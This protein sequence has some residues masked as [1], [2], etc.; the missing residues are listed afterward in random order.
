MAREF[1]C[2]ESALS[3]SLGAH[4]EELVLTGDADVRGVGNSLDNRLVGNTGDNVLDGKRGADTMAGGL[5]DDLYVVDDAGDVVTETDDAGSD[6]VRSAVDYGLG[7][8]IEHLKL[9]GKATSGAG[10]ALDNSVIGNARNNTLDGGDG[11]DTI[12]GGNGNDTLSGGAG[13][14]VLDGYKGA[15][16]AS[17]AGA[18]GAVNVDLALSEAQNT[19]AAGT[20]RLI[21]IERLIGGDYADTLAGN[22]KANHLDGGAGADTLSGGTGNDTYIV[23]DADDTVVEANRG[24]YDVVESAVSHTLAANVER[25]ELT[26]AD[27]IDATGNASRNVLKGNDG[28][29][30]L[31]GGAGGDRLVGGLGDDTYVVDSRYDR[32]VEARNGGVDEVKS[33]VHFTLASTLEHLELTGADNI[34]GV[35]NGLDNRLVGNTGD[36]VLDGKRGAD[37]MAGGRG[38]DLYVVDDAGDVVTEND[39]AGSDT[40]RSAVDYGLGDHIEHLKLT[41]K[42]TSGAGNALDNSVIGN[43]RNNTLDGG[44]GDDT[45]KGGNGND[46]L[47][48]GAGNDVLDGYKGADCASYA[49]ATGAVNVDLALSEAQNTGAAGTDR[50]IAIERLIGGDYAD[51]LAGNRKANHLDGGA[52]A[53][54]LSG[55]TGNDTYIVDDAGD[56]VVEANRGGYDVVESAV[57][58]TLAANV[59]RLELTGA[60]DI[61][62]T[63]NAS[64]N[65]LKGNDGANRLDGGAGGDRLVGGLGDDTYVVDSRYDRVVEARNGGVDEVKSAVHFTLA[66]TLEH[67]E[68]TGADNIKGVGNGLDNRLVGNTGDNVLDGKRGADTMA[69]GRGDDLYVVDDAGDVVTEN[70]TAGSDTVRSAVDYG[71]GD[72]IEHLKLTGKATSGAGNALD[73]SVIGNARNNTLDGGDG[74]DTIKGGN[75]NDTLSGGA[76]NDVLDGYKGADCASYAGATGA[77]NVDLALSEAQ[78][79][80]AAGTDRLIAIERLIGGDYAD[81]LAGNRKANHLDGGAGADTLSGGTG[82]DTYIVDDAGDTVVEANRGGYDV[83]ESAVSHTLAANVERLELTGA[84]DIDATGNASRNVLKGNDGANRLDGGAGGDRLVGGLGDD[85]YVVDS[86]YDRVVEARNGGVDEVKSAVH[87]TLSSTLEHLELTGANPVN[88]VGNSL[89]NR[90]VGNAGDNRLVGERRRRYAERRVRRRYPRGRIGR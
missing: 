11:D 59:E 32:V 50:L 52:G 12:K 10:N 47:S 27:D 74:D 57:S 84:D 77:V 28:A 65:V 56:T 71:L 24:G 73:N 39:T 9:T 37:T 22:R 17:Y 41:G 70:D 49:G 87:F 64:R 90:L 8:H 80:G 66:S 21:A 45:I 42:A 61:D 31:D 72:H 76:G 3:L 78:N 48:G 60:D 18:T 6:T 79:T 58:H 54:T 16:C 53:D 62:A 7:D 86:R 2:I 55:G 26:G 67:L 40:V 4:I 82:N 23:D 30:R 15:D 20:D 38:D 68:L 35:G 36:N 13:N 34:K 89:D 81:T 43:A 75:G 5:G 88:G 46:T 83:V 51:T 25:L 69:G 44:D 85:T 29:N 63:G 1:D 19:G 33:A 14:D